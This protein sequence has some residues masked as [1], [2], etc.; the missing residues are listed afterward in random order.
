MTWRSSKNLQS[1]RPCAGLKIMPQQIMLVGQAEVG[2]E[3]TLP[4]NKVPGAQ[5]RVES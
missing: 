3:G 4:C 1:R 5:S 2:R